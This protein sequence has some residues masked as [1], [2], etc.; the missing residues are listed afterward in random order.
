MAELKDGYLSVSEEVTL[1]YVE[2]GKAPG[3]APLVLFYHG[4]PSFWYCFHLQL[5]ALGKHFHVVAVD[6]LGA[7]KSSK[8][9]NLEPYKLPNLASQLDQLAR[10]LVGDEPFFLVG[11]DWGG[12]LSWAYAQHYP[13]RLKKL[14]VMSAPPANQLL[15]LLKTDEVQRER[16]AYMYSMREGKVHHVMTRDNN[17][18]VCDGIAEGLRKLPHYS[19]EMEQAFRAGLSTPGAVDAG[20]NW[21]RANIPPVEAIQAAD[22]WPGEFASTNVPALL[23][24][25]DSDPTF[26]DGFIDDL[27]TYASNLSVFRLPGVG[28]SPMYER[29]EEVNQKLL[30]FFS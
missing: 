14:V 24:W 16:S 4:F 1:H 21:Y 18:Q 12:A 15:K 22:F 7:N 30:A 8:P 28:H 17:Q 20:I 11:H 2:G 26:V 19:E 5:E 23:I 9:T 6:G 10:H 13:S 25:G 29:P 3:T 27:P